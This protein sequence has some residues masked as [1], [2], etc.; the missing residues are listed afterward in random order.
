MTCWRGSGRAATEL[1]LDL[2]THLAGV[3]ACCGSS[4][5]GDS[6]MG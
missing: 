6:W 3:E 2:E 5:G 1:E 4:D